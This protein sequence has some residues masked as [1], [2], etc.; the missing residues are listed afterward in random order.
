MVSSTNTSCHPWHVLRILD[1]ARLSQR[2]LKGPAKPRFWAV[3]GACSRLERSGGGRAT[4]LSLVVA[5][6]DGP[7]VGL[8]WIG[9]SLLVGSG[10]RCSGAVTLQ[11]PS[12]SLGTALSQH[13]SMAALAPR[14]TLARAS[15]SVATPRGRWIG[16][17][18]GDS[19]EISMN[20]G[21]TI[22]YTAARE[23]RANRRPRRVRPQAEVDPMTR[24]VRAGTPSGCHR[25]G[26]ERW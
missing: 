12:F 6:G 15:E 13:G 5:R 8:Q 3:D 9:L 17:K 21:Q 2:D 25:H 18:T 23:S 14:Q 22:W 24:L 10:F 11:G 26:P 4:P 7:T 19:K 1:P 20:S 16:R